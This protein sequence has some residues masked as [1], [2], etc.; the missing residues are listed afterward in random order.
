MMWPER[1]AKR[2]AFQ[3]LTAKRMIAAGGLTGLGRE[4]AAVLIRWNGLPEPHNDMIF[5]VI[6]CRWGCVGGVIVVALYLVLTMSLGLIAVRSK[7]P[8]VR[9]S[10]V[11]FAA[12]IFTQAAYNIAMTLGMIPITGIT[13]PFISYGGSSL[14][15]SFMM[16]GLALNFAARPPKWLARPSF[17]YEP[18]EVMLQ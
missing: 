15:A 5:A 6:C 2:E 14:L 7:D 13:L 11:G 12:M 17:E 8:F 9:L 10:L 3:G 18:T 1:Y 16:I 4:R